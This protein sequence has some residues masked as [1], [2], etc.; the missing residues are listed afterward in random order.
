MIL[1]LG[2]NVAFSQYMLSLAS[3][4]VYISRLLES[5]SP[6]KGVWAA[7]NGG[8]GVWFLLVISVGVWVG[9]EWHSMI[10]EW[11]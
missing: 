5:E 3:R 10:D 6:I 11:C 7:E 4:A 1:I 2:L 8:P 9:G